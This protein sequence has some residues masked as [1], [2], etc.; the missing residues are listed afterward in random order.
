MTLI[1]NALLNREEGH[2]RIAIWTDF[3]GVL[4]PPLAST[5]ELYCRNRLF[6]LDQ[7]RE[8]LAGV[9]QNYAAPD[10]MAVLDSG[11]LSERTWLAAISDELLKRFG[12]SDALAD[13]RKEWWSDRRTNSGWIAE[14]QSLRNAGAF[15]GVVSNL[16]I[17]WREQFL[18]N[19]DIKNFDAVIL[20]C[21]LGFR[22]PDRRMFDHLS[23]VSGV[24]GARSILIDDLVTNTEGADE[25][26]WKSFHFMGNGPAA[27]L[28]CRQIL[29][30]T[31]DVPHEP[32]AQNI[33]A[34]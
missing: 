30:T 10:A 22:K 9:A 3:R 15:V 19:V 6:T 31:D 16:P 32:N 27:G 23:A 28:F 34:R 13:F 5:L 33:D 12:V 4:T 21:D 24:P 25:A 29:T 14:L 1:P 8:A 7:L 11:I 17:E 2:P 20:S 26:G 18:E